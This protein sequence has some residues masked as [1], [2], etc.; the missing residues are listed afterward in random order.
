ME[1]SCSEALVKE[2]DDELKIHAQAGFPPI[3]SI[4]AMP[5]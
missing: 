2:L 1:L 5:T 4:F 3:P